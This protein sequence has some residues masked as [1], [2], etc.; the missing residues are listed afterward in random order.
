MDA[1]SGGN[2]NWGGGA[3]ASPTLSCL[4]S[5]LEE[6]GGSSLCA[7]PTSDGGGGGGSTLG[8]RF[9]TAATAAAAAAAAAS[10]AQLAADPLL[11]VIRLPQEAELRALES[12]LNSA[13]VHAIAPTRAAALLRALA[14]I[15]P[16]PRVSLA[17]LYELISEL[18]R[19]LTEL[20]ATRK[21]RAH[22]LRCAAAAPVVR[23]FQVEPSLP[24]PPPPRS[25]AVPLTVVVAPI[26]R[27][28]LP[29]QPP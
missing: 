3:T 21:E 22:E 14:V 28:H 17:R 27:P 29:I 11:S 9:A 12:E 7:V 5:V 16:S 4:S 18:V 1:L 2:A 26:L 15:G 6:G 8:L 24:Q 10:A 20:L 25:I 13:L 23:F 19:S